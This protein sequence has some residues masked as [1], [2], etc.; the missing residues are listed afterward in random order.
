MHNPTATDSVVRGAR[1]LSGI[2][3]SLTLSLVAC[4]GS[5]NDSKVAGGSGNGASGEGGSLSLQIPSSGGD[6]GDNGQGAGGSGSM[7][8]GTLPPGFTP[9]ELGGFKLGDQISVAGAAS[10]SGG[11]SGDQTSGGGSGPSSGC[12]TTILGVIR[13]FKADGVTFEGPTGDD[14]GV[15]A[16]MLGSD[17]KPVYAHT[18]ATATI[19]GPTIF[20]EFYRD[21]PGVNIPF[22]LY[23]FFAPNNGV[24]SFQSNA[25]FPLDGKGWGDDGMDASGNLHNFHFTTEIHTQFVYNGGETFNFTGDDDVWVFIND[26]LVIDLGGV[27]GAE[28]ASVDIDSQAAKLNLTKSS[29]Y[30]FDMFYNERHTVASDFRADTDLAFVDCGTIVPE[31]P[32][33]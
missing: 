12:G 22:E 13:D 33:K 28:N 2:M 26:Q 32:V 18:G 31:P 21:T 30:P 15:V 25:F 8:T 5:T 27:H 6:A 20:N 10:A 23:V 24:T 29:I 11:S 9:T 19:A 4:G 17:H 14:R 3:L 7:P 16:A 1:Y